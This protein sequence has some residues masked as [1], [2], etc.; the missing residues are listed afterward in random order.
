MTMTRTTTRTIAT[1]PVKIIDPE[2][3][4]T[5]LCKTW[6]KQGSC[7]YYHKCQFAHGEEELRTRPN[8]KARLASRWASQKSAPARDVS[9][10]RGSTPPICSPCSSPE[11][12]PSD[13]DRI[14]SPPMVAVKTS[15]LLEMPPGLL[16]PGLLA[17]P[18]SLAKPPGLLEKPPGLLE[19]PPGLLKTP[20][21][22]EMPVAVLA[23]SPGLVATPS[24]WLSTPP[25]L[26]LGVLE[27]EPLE[28]QHTSIELRS[29]EQHDDELAAT[30]P[31]R[32]VT[33]GPLDFM[34]EGGAAARFAA[35]T[36]T[37]SATPESVRALWDEKRMPSSKWSPFRCNPKTGRVE[38]NARE[39]R[40]L[41]RK[42]SET[43][44]LVRR[45]ISFVLESPMSARRLKRSDS[46][47]TLGSDSRR[48]PEHSPM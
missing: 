16:P 17:K 15:R 32:R 13:S 25:G 2:K 34:V 20:L 47:L 5:T 29:E 46:R 26:Q 6:A 9:S 22:L 39:S 19:K 10:R 18:Q 27:L 42:A 41:Q 33:F 3:Y 23:N 28:S 45:A 35:P 7:P 31:S 38:S 44:L 24:N 4:K 21:D 14:S 30:K 37:V 40:L 12:V 48:S 11:T 8:Q 43:G 36:A 1:K